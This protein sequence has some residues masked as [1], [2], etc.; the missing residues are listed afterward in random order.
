MKTLARLE[1]KGYKV[2]F[3]MQDSKVCFVN[4]IRYENITQ[5]YKSLK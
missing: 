3:S 2:T 4:G 5:A 1:R